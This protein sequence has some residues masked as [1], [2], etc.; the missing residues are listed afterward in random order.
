MFPWM[1]ATLLLV[2][3]SPA[4]A[5]RKKGKRAKRTETPTEETVAATPAAVPPETEAVVLP[6]E[7]ETGQTFV[8]E[9]ER[10]RTDTNNPVLAKIRNRAPVTIVVTEMRAPGEARFTYDVGTSSLDAPEELRDHP[11]VRALAGLDMPAMTLDMQQGSV[12]D[13]V[14]RLE[15]VDAM[16]P[17]LKSS[18]PADAPPHILE[19]T[20]EMFRDPATGTQLM[21]RDPG[22]LFAMHCVAL[23]PG[24]V[25]E[26]P[27]QFP[28]PFGGP[29]IE[30]YS[31]IEF[32][33]Y[34]AERGE[35]TMQTEDGT[36]PEAVR[37]MIPSVL[38]RFAPDLDVQDVEAAMAELPPIESVL[39]GTMV[40]SVAD[41]FPYRLEVR[42]DVGAAGHPQHK[43]DTWIWT[44][45]PAP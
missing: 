41:G 36:S 24:Q 32:V 5:A 1:L 37:A 40:Y 6:C 29:P 45:V 14:N 26:S 34:D 27:V 17:I 19:Q 9:H 3:A 7:W 12:V 44:R 18:I 16:E 39:R 4:D 38:A 25:I 22:K 20:L 23:S 21:L 8:Y 2:A 43:S 31:R 28:N 33:E 15:L 13:V 42:A 30:G 11:S 35:L 10:R